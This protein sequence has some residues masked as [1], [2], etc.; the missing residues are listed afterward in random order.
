VTD[1]NV[2]HILGANRYTTTAATNELRFVERPAGATSVSLVLQQRWLVQE[3]D[4][5]VVV[6][7]RYEWLDIPIGKEEEPGGED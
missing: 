3:I 4:N 7:A 1:S 6:A 5:H 2:T